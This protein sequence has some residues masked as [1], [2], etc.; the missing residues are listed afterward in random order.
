MRRGA[1]LLVLLATGAAAQDFVRTQV[2]GRDPALPPLCLTWGTRTITWSVNLA[3]SSKTPGDTEFAAIEA[4]FASWQA[5]NAGCSDFTL[6]AGPRVPDT[7]VG[8]GTEAQR[9]L[10]FREQAC[11]E[12]V[13]AGDA[14]WADDTCANL[15]NCWDGDDLTYASTLNTYSVRTGTIA[16]S[17]IEFNAAP[18]S[19]GLTWLF[20]TISAPPCPNL[21]LQQAS[22]VAVDVQ[23]TLTHEIG[24]LFGFD[25]APSPISTMYGSADI[26]EISKRTIDPGTQLGFCTAYPAGEPAL[27]CDEQASL[28]R[29]IIAQ[30]AGTPGLSG[31]GCSAGTGA[32][33]ALALVLALA[34]IRRARKT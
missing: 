11:R 27:P 8:K 32:P 22:C 12:A 19:G 31:L 34:G 6:T 25:H 18:Q 24:H 2:Q 17:D 13:P 3:G 26:G 5:V 30:G 1:A 14:C 28:R 9:L 23:N 16:D 21:S 10:V 7:R 29:K 33:L 15:Y 4:A 20:T